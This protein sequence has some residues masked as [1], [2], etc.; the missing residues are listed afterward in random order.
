VNRLVLALVLAAAGFAQSPEQRA[1][2]LV[3]RMTL[4][5]K[6][7]Q[8]QNAAP[9]IP[10]LG[11]PEYNWW[12]EA[13]HG[14]ARA[15]LATSF[16]QAIALAATW[17]TA[18]V[19]R[20]SAAIAEEARAKYNQSQREGNRGAYH[21]LTFWSPNINLYRDP[22]W[23]RGHETYGEDPLLTG[24]MAVAFIGGLQ[25]DDP[26]YLKAIATPKHFAAHSGPDLARHSFDSIVSGRDLDASYLAAFRSAITSGRAQSIMC[27][28]NSINGV[29][30][31]ANRGLLEGRLRSE[32]GFEGFVV[33]DCGAIG[34]IASGHHYRATT[35]EAAVSALEAGTDL[36]CGKEFT[37]LADA[38]RQGLVGEP[39]LDRALTRLFAAR[40]R[41][42]MFDAPEDVPYSSIPVSAID[43][44]A[45]R[46]L[47][48]D[49]A[50]RSIVLL[51]NPTG[52][53]PLDPGARKRI[54][55]IGPAAD[56]PDM[57]LANYAGVPSHVVTPLE[58]IRR[59]FAGSVIEYA[60]G[61]TYTATYPALVPAG[62]GFTA[63]YFDNAGF[64]GPPALTR[65]EPRIDFNWDRREP[66]IVSAVARDAFSVRWTGNLVAPYTGGYSIALAPADCHDCAGTQSLAL[67]L[68]GAPAPRQVQM[69]AGSVHSLRVEYSQQR[70][71]TGVKLTWIPPAAPM[72]AE[73]ERSIRESEMALLF[74]GLNSNIE[75][76]DLDRETIRLPATQQTL[77][78]AALAT[79]KPVVVVLMTGGSIVAEGA[80][81]RAAAVLQA[82]YPGQEGG[83]AIA[84]TL[85]GDNN[86]SGRLPVTFYRSD[87]QLPSFDD[88]S[89]DGRT[90][91]FFNG[92]PLYPFGHGLSY[93]TFAYSDL[94]VERAGPLL[95]VTVAVANMAGPEGDEVVQVYAS[96]GRDTR[97]SHAALQA[98]D[99]V[100]LAPGQRQTIELTLSEEQ[101]R[102]ARL[103]RVG[104]LVA[105]VPRVQPPKVR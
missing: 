38:V 102:A 27:A 103:V 90:Y 19:K 93:S 83:T 94:T 29:P 98:V 69:D 95:R 79:G 45:H 30:A 21:G 78:D 40:I 57:Q 99:R 89:M 60:P 1:A 2:A 56:A 101:A 65:T 16:P 100:H 9:A 76:E 84:E 52:F 64:S 92:T 44:P 54:A 22:R 74:L 105:A 4:D 81:E 59:R 15:G 11:I 5:E 39:L 23:G 36:S 87:D 62:D 18:L 61:S 6:S 82:W 86:P 25:G 10:R 42:G 66:A 49:A 31:C 35:V 104:S 58:A 20:V 63:E 37:L 96:G 88:Y 85:A 80:H 24:R 51:D 73:A 34:D 91:R 48:L 46:A 26:K 77:L 3:S 70:G 43:S 67:S 53:L 28:Y 68:D 33:S 75:G 97:T 17:D 13:L 41:L 71:G 7:S 50:R 47:A 12:N 8:M 55:V 32:W 14:V 72:L